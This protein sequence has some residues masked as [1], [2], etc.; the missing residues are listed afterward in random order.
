[1][2][3]FTADAVAVLSYLADKLPHKSN[4]IFNCIQSITSFYLR[5]G[6]TL[7]YADLFLFNRVDSYHLC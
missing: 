1:M 2:K 3:L 4:E 6:F 7:I 5:H